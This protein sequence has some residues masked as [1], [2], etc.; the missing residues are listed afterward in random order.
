[1]KNIRWGWILLGGFLAELA[2]FVVVIPLSIM[3]GQQSLLYSAPPASFVAS[4]AFGIWVARKTQQRR[5]LHGALVGIVATLIYVGID[6]GRP[7]P[8]A[9]V[10]VHV[11]KVLGGAAGRVR[12]IEA[13]R[14]D[15]RF[16]CT[17][18]AISLIQ[19]PHYA[20]QEDLFFFS[21]RTD[22]PCRFCRCHWTIRTFTAF[23]GRAHP[24]MGRDPA[25]AVGRTR[26]PATPAHKA[27]GAR[28]G[29]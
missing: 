12:R 7:E 21:V 28:A 24:M 5:V 11:L 4:F 14:R 17:A 23:S 16:H 27:A 10:V 1:M 3:A 8:I 6:L 18:S 13:G 22:N 9:Y 29:T 15:R 25:I 26:S 19:T 20:L 2:V